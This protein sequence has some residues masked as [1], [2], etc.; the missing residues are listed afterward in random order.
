MPALKVGSVQV[1]PPEILR[2]PDRFRGSCKHLAD[3]R[4]HSFAR[5]NNMLNT[6]TPQQQ[7]HSYHRLKD[8]AN[9]Q[10]TQ[11]PQWLSLAC[12]ASARLAAAPEL[13]VAMARSAEFEESQLGV[14]SNHP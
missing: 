1:R 9:W 12:L 13:A 6:P 3:G 11:M 10:K 14:V 8:G 2:A 5:V 4:Q 7:G